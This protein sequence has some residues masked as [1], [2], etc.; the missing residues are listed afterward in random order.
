[1][2]Q[3]IFI[4][5]LIG[6]SAAAIFAQPPR[7]PGKVTPRN[8]PFKII[9]EISDADWQV[10]AN[11]LYKEEWK[12]SAT[13]AARHL[14]T[15]KTENDKKQ[16]AQLR[17]IYL[18]ALAGQILNANAQ[19]N[20]LEYEKARTEMETAMTTFIG[21]EFLLPPR[22]FAADCDR[23]L[24][25]VCQVKDAPN[26]FRT[27]ATNSEGNAIHSFDYVQLDQPVNLTAFADKKVFAGGILRKA[28]SNEDKTKPWVLRLFFDKGFLRVVI[29]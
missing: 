27:T 6:I 18:F 12:Q 7:V 11:A 14:Q 29:N 1:M 26:T 17:Y 25:V 2:R 20:A 4:A 19:G 23:K 3:S 16:L 5:L 10:L 13:L 21:K 9:T 24:N 28:E 15:L 22:L 8:V